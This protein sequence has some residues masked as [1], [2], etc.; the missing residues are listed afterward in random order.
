R[1]RGGDHV[2]RKQRNAHGRVGVLPVE[3]VGHG[4][5]ERAMGE[6]SDDYSRVAEMNKAKIRWTQLKKN[7]RFSR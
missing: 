2:A 3:V 7:L 5:A 4:G 1:V 6:V